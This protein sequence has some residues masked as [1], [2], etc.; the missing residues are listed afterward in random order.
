M[1]LGFTLVLTGL[2][3]IREFLAQGTLFYQA[4]LM[5][6]EG[7]RFLSLAWGPE[8]KGALLAILPPGAFITLGLLIAVKNVVDKV[9]A[10][11]RVS[12]ALPATSLLEPGGTP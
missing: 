11:R 12:Q 10:R 1:G 8:F 4:D 3:A 6:G 9:L 7:A 2:G 5:F